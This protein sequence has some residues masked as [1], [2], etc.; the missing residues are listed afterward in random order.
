MAV[1][2][3]AWKAVLTELH[4]VVSTADR[5]DVLMVDSMVSRRVELLVA[6]WVVSTVSLMAVDSVVR[7]AASKGGHS[8]DNLVVN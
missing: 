2:S 4:L 6:Y 5:L 7:R 3:A 1:H 8:V